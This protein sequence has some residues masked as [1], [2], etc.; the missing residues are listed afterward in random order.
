MRNRGIIAFVAGVLLTI[1]AP[2]MA[3]SWYT[4][5]PYGGQFETWVYQH[6]NL[7]NLLAPNPYLVYNPG[8]RADHPEIQEYFVAHPDIWQGMRAESTTYYDQRFSEF[9][10]N[11]PNIAAQLAADPA[12]LYNP[13]YIA[14]HP[15]LAAFLE[16]HPNVWRALTGGYAGTV[17]VD[18]GNAWGDYDNSRVWHDYYWW[19]QY[20]PD[21]F[22]MHHPEWAANEPSWRAYDG[23][24]DENH[25]WHDRNWWAQ[26]RAD[27]VR[28]HHRDWGDW[29]ENHQWHDRDWWTQ[30]RA[31]WVASNHPNWAQQRQAYQQ[32]LRNEQ[33]KAQQQAVQIQQRRQQQQSAKLEEQKMHKMPPAGGAAAN[34]GAPPMHRMPPVAVA[35]PMHRMPPV[36]VAP[37]MHRMPP[38][39]VA[40]PMHRMPPASGGTAKGGEPAM[41]RMPPSEGSI[42]QQN[43]KTRQTFKSEPA[44]HAAV[45]ESKGAS[46]ASEKTH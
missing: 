24:W 29:D 36:A 35:P 5:G 3:Q 45:H 38:V 13:N 8:W 30:N 25:Q 1:A 42:A 18:Y 21:W 10:A 32:G 19:H 9:L 41:H 28:A 14:A 11:H 39:A 27:W 17:P 6:P 37:P 34:S 15:R 46:G 4:G 7:A 23:D 22:W 16:T 33:L 12:L 43:V 26:N 2:A 31:S 20:H 44:P 40:P